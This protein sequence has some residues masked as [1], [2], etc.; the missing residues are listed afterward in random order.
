M[1]QLSGGLQIGLGVFLALFVAAM[2]GMLLK[3]RLPV[4]HRSRETQD[5]LS[6][7]INMIA[8]LSAVVL[9]LLTASVKQQFDST[10]R[11]VQTYSASLVELDRNLRAFGPEAAPLHMALL[12]YTRAALAET[13]PRPGVTPVVDSPASA[14]RIQALQAGVLGLTPGTPLQTRLLPVIDSQIVSVVTQRWNL[15]ARATE[16]L[17]PS[18][19]IVMVFWLGLIFLGLGLTAPANALTAVTI[20]LCALALGSLVFLTVEMDGAFDGLIRV[21]ADPLTAA[22]N[23]MS[24]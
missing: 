18:L 15:I 20:G 6:L 17:S 10:E 19:L 24:H 12:D 14:A 9:G 13:W 11:A 16:T 4:H 3:P 22:C 8:T 21:S 2:I 1:P 5:A 7:S 23:L